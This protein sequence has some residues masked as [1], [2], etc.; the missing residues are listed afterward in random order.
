LWAC[1]LLL[2]FSGRS[3]WRNEAITIANRFISDPECVGYTKTIVRYVNE[4]I[5]GTGDNLVRSRVNVPLAIDRH[6]VLTSDGELNIKRLQDCMTM[7]SPEYKLFFSVTL[8]EY[9]QGGA[10]RNYTA[11]NLP[12]KFSNDNTRELIQL[13]VKIVDDN[14][15]NYGLFIVSIS[16]SVEYMLAKVL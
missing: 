12:S 8:L 2:A 6:K 16:I 1:S 10:T 4:T 5:G 11:A 14:S 9:T 7:N 15:F 3:D 13:P